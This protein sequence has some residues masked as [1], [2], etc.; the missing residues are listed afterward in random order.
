METRSGAVGDWIGIA[1]LVRPGFFCVR[2]RD[3]GAVGSTQHLVVV[4][5]YRFVRNPMYLAVLM[6]IAGWSVAFCSRELVWYGLLV[7]VVFHLRVIFHEEPWLRR[8]FGNEWAAY[9]A[10]VGRWFPRGRFGRRGKPL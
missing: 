2:P 4:G 9:S 1:S 10:S 7:A 6:V 8:Q 3:A 5:L